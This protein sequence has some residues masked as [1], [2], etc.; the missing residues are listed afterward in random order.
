MHLAVLAFSGVI[1]AINEKRILQKILQTNGLK[2]I[3]GIS[4]FDVFTEEILKAKPIA[5]IEKALELMVDRYYGNV[6]SSCFVQ[7]ETINAWLRKNDL[8]KYIYL[9]YG[10]NN[11]SRFEHFENLARIEEGY[12]WLFVGNEPD[13]F[14]QIYEWGIRKVAVNVTNSSIYPKRISVFYEPLSADLAKEITIGG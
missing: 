7:E 11:G 9:V 12:D 3:E 1:A 10:V 14:V 4:F 2:N 5:G 8:D 13:D 6:I